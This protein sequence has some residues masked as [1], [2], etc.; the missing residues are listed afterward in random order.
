LLE[1]HNKP[2]TTTLPHTREIMRNRKDK[3]AEIVVLGLISELETLV[4]NKEESFKSKTVHYVGVYV[5]IESPIYKN[6]KDFD[7]R[8]KFSQYSTNEE[9]KSSNISNRIKFKHLLEDVIKVINSEGILKTERK[10]W[11][12]ELSNW[13][14]LG[15]LFAALLIG[16]GVG[17]WIEKYEVFKKE[18]NELS[19]DSRLST[20]DKTDNVG[21]INKGTK[22]TNS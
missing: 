3:N 18:K 14:I 5:G 21:Y 9:N 1:T 22:E 6:I 19:F 7:I 12:S 2:Y 20:F 11:F 16:I 17:R 4:Y 10:N 13:K 8:N 15:V